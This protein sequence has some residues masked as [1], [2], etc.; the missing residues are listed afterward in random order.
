MSHDAI[1]LFERM[2]WMELS[3]SILIA[4]LQF[5]LYG[6]FNHQEENIS[7]KEGF[8]NCL[9][10]GC[11]KKEKEPS[12]CIAANENCHYGFFSL[13][14]RTLN[15]VIMQSPH[16]FLNLL[17]K[18]DIIYLFNYQISDGKELLPPAAPA[19]SHGSPP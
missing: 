16:D 1:A 17:N 2:F 4:S 11:S 19:H 15:T 5:L 13:H 3:A 8:R 12:A 10:F 7:N 6:V 9:V 18:E 14:L